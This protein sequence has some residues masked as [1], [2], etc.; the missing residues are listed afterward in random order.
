ME[1]GEAVRRTMDG[2]GT[3]TTAVVSAITDVRGVGTGEVTPLHESV[4]PDALN[5]L[6]GP[7]TRRSRAGTVEFDHDDCRVEL[8]YGDRATVEVTPLG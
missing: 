6:F 3:P 5:S 2:T 7:T 1:I 4:D 8:S